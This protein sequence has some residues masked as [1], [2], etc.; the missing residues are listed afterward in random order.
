MSETAP[1]AP[2]GIAC[3]RLSRRPP[4]PRRVPPLGLR[5]LN[6]DLIP[7]HDE[8]TNTA[9]VMT[10]PPAVFDRTLVHPVWRRIPEKRRNLCF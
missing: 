5:N 10:P 6:P 1:T 2:A 7:C 3:A 9:K 8:P 4:G